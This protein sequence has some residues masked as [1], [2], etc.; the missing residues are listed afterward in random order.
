MSKWCVVQP[1]RW[2]SQLGPIPAFAQRW[3][4]HMM[5][6]YFVFLLMSLEVDWVVGQPNAGSCDT[7]MTGYHHWEKKIYGS[8]ISGPS[9]H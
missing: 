9:I 7:E 6:H 1:G 5:S 4:A 3:V 2:V 8:N